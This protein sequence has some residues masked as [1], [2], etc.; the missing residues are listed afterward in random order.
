MIRDIHPQAPIHYLIIPRKHV[1][2]IQQ[3][4]PEDLPLAQDIFAM[5]Q[6]L[7]LEAG[8][9]KLQINSGKKAGQIV[10]HL[11]AHFLAN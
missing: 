11:H 3:F 10:M 8:D 2:D 5:A 6:Q 4:S 7:S 9:F 1:Q